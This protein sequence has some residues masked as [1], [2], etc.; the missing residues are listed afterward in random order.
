MRS[1]L[2]PGLA[3]ITI[4]SVV[5]FALYWIAGFEITVI[6]LLILILVNN[7]EPEVTR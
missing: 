5:M 1:S 6:S 4:L 7:I 3:F 2:K